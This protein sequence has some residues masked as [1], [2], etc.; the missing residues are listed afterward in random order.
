MFFSWTEV[1]A[2]RMAPIFKAIVFDALLSYNPFLGRK[3]KASVV[4]IAGKHALRRP[5]D[6]CALAWSL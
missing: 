4:P 5:R 6:D 3:P 2:R 1:P